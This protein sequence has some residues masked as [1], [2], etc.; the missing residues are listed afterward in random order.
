MKI[1]GVELRNFMLFDELKT[2]FSPNMN[3]IIGENSTGKTALL[4]ALYAS[5]KCWRNHN[6]NSLRGVFRP[7]NEDI[8][9][10]ANRQRT[11]KRTVMKVVFHDAGSFSFG[12]GGE[13]MSRPNYPSMDA[14]RDSESAVYIPTGEMLSHTENFASLYEK[15]HIPFDETCYALV[16]LLDLPQMRKLPEALKAVAEAL[17]KIIGGKVVQEG[18]VFYLLVNDTERIE[19]SLV[20]DGYRKLATLL[21]LLQS[22]ALTDGSILLWDEPEA[23]MNPRMAQ[24]LVNA[25]IA[26]AGAGVQVFVTTH[27]FFVQQYFGLASTY[28]EKYGADAGKLDLR[29]FSLYRETVERDGRPDSVIK[30]ESAARLVDLKHNAVTEEN[31]VLGDREMGLIYGDDA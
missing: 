26:V 13:K 25:L 24:T 19:M 28:K 18:R 10:L 21:A 2:E 22:G 30:I 16:R 17:E 23:N 3:I 4:K 9:R 15:Y 6:T 11:N 20:S 5:E 14:L 27:D 29:F 7:I 1:H 12:F 8:F 31:D